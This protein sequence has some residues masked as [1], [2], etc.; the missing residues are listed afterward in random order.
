MRARLWALGLASGLA[1]IAMTSTAN[2]CASCA[3]EIALTKAQISCLEGRLQSYLSAEAD[4]VMVSLLGCDDTAPVAKDALAPSAAPILAPIIESGGD[5]DAADKLLFL[6]RGQIVCLRDSLE[7]L[8]SAT[9]E[10]VVFKFDA[11]R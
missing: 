10:P 2:A 11:C 9:G 3:S 1:A 4:P 8:K 6:T 5:A 7:T